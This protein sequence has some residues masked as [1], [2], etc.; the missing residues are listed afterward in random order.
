MSDSYSTNLMNEVARFLDS[1]NY[2]Y[3]IDRDEG[4]IMM[5]WNFSKCR[6]IREGTVFISI[7]SKDVSFTV[8][9]TINGNCFNQIDVKDE[10]RLVFCLLFMTLANN[11]A[12]HASFQ[13]DVKDGTICSQSALYCGDYKPPEDF[14]AA[15]F[16]AA[17]H[18]WEDYGDAFV[19]VVYRHRDPMEAVSS[20]ERNR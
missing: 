9:P 6:S 18:W 13:L 5:P 17:I 15:K 4:V 19:D 16:Y 20:A 12:V 3:K 8:T 1:R 14:I 11:G 10:G 2:H 7:R